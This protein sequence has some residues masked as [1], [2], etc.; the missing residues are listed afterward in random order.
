MT[1]GKRIYNAFNNIKV[2]TIKRL[3]VFILMFIFILIISVSECYADKDDI[4]QGEVDK[5]LTQEVVKSDYTYERQDGN[6]K[7]NIRTGINGVTKVGAVTAL[8]IDINNLGNE[9]SGFVKVGIPQSKEGTLYAEKITIGSNVVT[10]VNVY[11]PVNVQTDMLK[12]EIVN[13]TGNS[14]FKDD[15]DIKSYPKG[16]YMI[17]VLAD[18]PSALTYLFSNKDSRFY[19]YSKD[20]R[21]ILLQ[22][23][24]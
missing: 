8:T 24:G 11:I 15:I 10:S 1:T 18:K 22:Q 7:V 23:L 16:C 12:F 21:H 20:S 14:C 13:E 3:I 6:L 4:S 2:D 5:E 17:G 9:F 19:F